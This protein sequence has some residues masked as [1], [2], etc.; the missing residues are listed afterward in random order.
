MSNDRAGSEDDNLDNPTGAEQAAD[1]SAAA[2]AD[3]AAATA[4][5]AGASSENDGIGEADFA[6]EQTD[7]DSDV[8]LEK[9]GVGAAAAGS[10]RAAARRA[11]ARSGVTEGKN[12]PTRG[13]EDKDEHSN[14]FSRIGRF[15]REVIAELGKVIWPS[16]KQM[17]TYTIVVIVFLIFMIALVSGLDLLFGWGVRSIFG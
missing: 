2:A 15:L 1:D 14:V 9:V 13:R 16:Q 4:T 12:A 17:V 3:D 6:P 8:S 7:E 11:G 5:P 10:A